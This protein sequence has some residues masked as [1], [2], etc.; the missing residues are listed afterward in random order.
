MFFLCISFISFPDRN[1]SIFS[2]SSI[3]NVRVSSSGSLGLYKG[4]NVCEQTYPNQTVFG[5]KQIDWCSNIAYDKEDP[6]I[7]YSI[8]H[9]A[10]KLTGYSIRNGCCYYTCSCDSSTGKIID[11]YCCCQLYSFVFEGSN[12]NITW[13]EIHKVERDPKFYHCQYKTYEFPLTQPFSIVRIRLVETPRGCPKCLQINQ[14]QLYGETIPH[15]NSYETNDNDES[16]SI[17]GKI[18]KY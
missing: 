8:Q 12:D 7:Q 1:D 11:Y 6:W 14:V 5:D 9:K 17:I 2:T 13:T 3:N 15:Y 4:K 18:K 16:I 10:M